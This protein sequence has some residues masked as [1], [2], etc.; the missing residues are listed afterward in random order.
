MVLLVVLTF[1]GTLY[2]VDYQGGNMPEKA[3][4]TFFSALYVTIPPGIPLPGMPIVCCLLFINLIIGGLIRLRRTPSRWG[5]F[6]VHGGIALLLASVALGN[7]KTE[8]QDNIQLF[9][10]DTQYYPQLGFSIHLHQFT[11]EFYPG[12]QKP[13]SF[14]SIISITDKSGQETYA[15]HVRIQMNEPF[16]FRGWTMYQMSWGQYA[17]QVYSVLRASHNPFEQWPKWISCMIT[18]GLFLYYGMMFAAY[19]KGRGQ[20]YKRNAEQEL[21]E[22]QFIVPKRSKLAILGLAALVFALFAVC[23]FMVRPAVTVAEIPNYIPWSPELQ[24]AMAQAAVEDGGRV[25]P[26]DT[27]AG[28]VML[29]V[30]GQKSLT[31]RSNGQKIRLTPTE[32]ALDCMLRPEYANQMPVF[33]V[34]RE[35]TVSRLGLPAVPGK[36][37]QYSYQQLFPVKD[38]IYAQARRIEAQGPRDTADREIAGLA[39]NVRQ[40][41]LWTNMIAKSVI[42]R[43]NMEDR[44]YPRWYCRQNAWSSL[45]TQQEAFSMATVSNNARLAVSNKDASLHQKAEQGLLNGFLAEN[46]KVAAP[47]E[48]KLQRELTYYRIDPLYSSLAFFIAGFLCVVIGALM[49]LQV[50]RSTKIGRLINWILGPGIRFPWIAGIIGAL[51][52]IAA[53]TLRATITMRSPVGNTYEV[54]SFIACT[55][56]IVALVME[57]YSRKGIILGIGLILGGIACQMGILYEAGQASDHMDPLVAVLRSNVLLSTHVITIVLGYAAG[58]LGAMISHVAVLAKPMNLLSEQTSKTLT[59]MAYGALGFSLLFTLIGTV[60]GGIWGNEAWGR[61]WG[62][63]PKENGALLIV[64]CQLIVLHARSAGYIKTLGLHLGNMLC[65]VAI[66]FAWWGVNTMGVGLHSYGFSDAQSLL[67]TFYIAEIVLIGVA[68][69]LHFLRSTRPTTDSE[70]P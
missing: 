62:W 27:Y 42:D 56:V 5:L 64:L 34:N 38:L 39:Q 29:R 12:T 15:D 23:L 1:F 43:S 33:L 24:K 7:W 30:H 48:G 19:L 28:F 51:I 9:P 10:G 63:D 68:I 22:Q 55:G 57:A 65:G 37:K 46:L 49:P 40:V 11:P 35:E 66:V 47:Y 41:E 32:W 4:E 53:M 36:R 44:G 67:H 58:L 31:F 52:L 59:R 3:A 13:K 20:A 50:S 54:I 17:G 18:A 60:F 25:K 8:I 2:Q 6:I 26:F 69:G 16:R 61:F 45:P 14:V 70:K 21:D